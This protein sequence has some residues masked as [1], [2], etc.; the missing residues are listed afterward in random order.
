V[1][2]LR[3]VG[4]DHC[5]PFQ[6]TTWFPAVAT[7][8]HSVGLAHDTETAPVPMAWGAAGTGPDQADPLN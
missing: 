6:L 2:P 4:A 1:A 3:V 5:W 7:A 8:M